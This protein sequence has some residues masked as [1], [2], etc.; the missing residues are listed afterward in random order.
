M[1]RFWLLAIG[2]GAVSVLIYSLAAIAPGGLFFAYFTA[3]PLYLVGFS[4]GLNAAATAGVAATI[5]VWFPGGGVTAMVFLA[6][7]TAPTILLVRQALLSRNDDQGNPA[8]Y[9]AGHIVFI[10]CV[11]GALIYSVVALWLAFLPDGF[12]GSVRKFAEGMADMLL[13]QSAAD[14]RDLFVAKIAPVLPGFAVSSWLIMTMINAALAQ[15]V[16]VR[17]QRNI[18]PSPDI[19]SMD[20]PYWF[21]LAGATAAATAAGL[22]LPGSI[23]YYGVN[24]AIILFIPFFFVG[25]AVVHTLCRNKPVGIIL[26][27]LFYG[28][29]IIFDRLI[30]VVAALGL[31]EQWVGLRRRFT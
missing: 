18:R 8:W 21:P 28:M 22:L 20:L 26:L 10:L 24:L 23:G 7:T 31:I 1:S 2:G 16:L 17:F 5:G 25:L 9:P 19:V 12:E 27:I 14:F 6:V 3:L 4:L 30:I 15:G 11:L 13:S 29:L